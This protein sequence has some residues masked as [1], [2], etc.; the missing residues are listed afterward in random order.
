M[1]KRFEEMECKYR[2]VEMEYETLKYKIESNSFWI[3]NLKIQI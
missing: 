2:I 3:F 1:S